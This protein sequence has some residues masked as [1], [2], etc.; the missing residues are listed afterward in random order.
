MSD[1]VCNK[2]PDEPHPVMAAHE[3]TLNFINKGAADDDSGDTYPLG[4]TTAKFQREDEI[5]GSRRASSA[6]LR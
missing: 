4:I 2:T 1:D 6:I 5:R 3:K